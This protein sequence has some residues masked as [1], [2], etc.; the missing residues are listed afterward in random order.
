MQTGE[1]LLQALDRERRREPRRVA[2]GVSSPHGQKERRKRVERR[3][4]ARDLFDA[5]ELAEEVAD[6]PGRMPGEKIEI[7]TVESVSGPS[8]PRQEPA[9][10]ADPELTG[11]HERI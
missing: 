3:V 4:G 9:R 6:E 5:T 1:E 2:T 11:I 7:R 10:P 8:G